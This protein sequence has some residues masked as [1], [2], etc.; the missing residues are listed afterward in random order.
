M[1]KSVAYI[2]VFFGSLISMITACAIL[3]PELA[4]GV[5]IV[6]MILGICTLVAV[7]F[8]YYGD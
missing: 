5:V 1:N 6:T 7:G 3:T 4:S 2:T 8:T